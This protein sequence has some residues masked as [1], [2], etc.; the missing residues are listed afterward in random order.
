MKELDIAQVSQLAGLP[1]STL[2]FYEKKGLIRSTGRKGLRRQYNQAVLDQLAL[3]ALGRTAGFTLEDIT[4]MFDARGK[5]DI[6]RK[7]LLAKAE[8]INKSIVRLRQVRDSL[9]QVA[10]CT[11]PDHMQCPEFRKILSKL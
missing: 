10:K 6:D 11:A 1:P 2:R 3:I 9:K 8:V 7:K 5:V 4:A